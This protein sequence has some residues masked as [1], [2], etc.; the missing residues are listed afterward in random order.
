MNECVKYEREY[1]D[2]F[3][4]LP[5]EGGMIKSF[6]DNRKMGE[7]IEV[8]NSVIKEIINRGDHG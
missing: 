8:R 2:A 3:L 4:E 1:G 7:H 5:K 6:Q